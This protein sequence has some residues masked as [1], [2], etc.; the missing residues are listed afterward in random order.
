MLD[1]CFAPNLRPLCQISG[2]LIQGRKIMLIGW[3]GWASRWLFSLLLLAAVSSPTLA[4]SNNE[5]LADLYDLKIPDGP[6][7]HPAVVVVPGCDGFGNT[8]VETTYNKTLDDYLAAGFATI[9]ADYIAASEH[10]KCRWNSV[11]LI[12]KDQVD[13]DISQ[14]LA[15]LAAQ[16]TIKRSAVNLVGWGDGAGS[17]LRFLS[18]R[19]GKTPIPVAAVVA[20]YPNCRNITMWATP[21]P[22]LALFAGK[23]TVAPGKICR[24]LF[25]GEAAKLIETEQ[26]PE[27]YHAFDMEKLPPKFKPMAYFDKGTVGYHPEAAKMARERVL[28]FLKR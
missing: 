19:A 6:G 28:K 3:M 24:Q 18:K 21:T 22:V 27:A 5:W 17:A 23:D 1:A 15:H 7:P 2:I 13:S 12:T 11:D 14:T 20:Y 10:P 9:R 16:K 4:D 8:W 25:S 26:Y